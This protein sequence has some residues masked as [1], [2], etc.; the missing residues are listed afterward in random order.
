MRRL[1][2]ASPQEF[3]FIPGW[4]TSCPWTDSLF[5]EVHCLCRVAPVQPKRHILCCLYIVDNIKEEDMLG[6]QRIQGTI[7]ALFVLIAVP[8]FGAAESPEAYERV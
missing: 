7:L 3:A 1:S 2:V 5:P 4:E 8:A 6:I